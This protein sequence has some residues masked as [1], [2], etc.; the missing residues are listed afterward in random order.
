MKQGRPTKE[1]QIK[2]KQIILGYYEKDI[3]AIVAAR[4]SGVNPKT[5]YKYYKMWNSQMNNPDEKDFLLRIKKT[6]E[7]SIQLLEED[8]ISLTKEMLKINF[9]MEK[10]LQKGDIS[11]YEKLSKLRLKTMDQRTKTVSAKI[12]LV[13]TPTADVLISNE[14]IMA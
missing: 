13:G 8:I 4:D 3:S 2:N 11:E 9:L 10:S 6:K 1:D 12:N 14:G 5:V 7:R